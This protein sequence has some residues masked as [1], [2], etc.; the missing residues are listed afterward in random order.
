MSILRLCMVRGNHDL[1]TVKHYTNMLLLLSSC[2]VGSNSLQPR[3]VQ[4]TRLPC[5]S[6]S[7]TVCSNSCPLNW[8]FHPTIS[9][10][11]FPF[12]SYLQSFSYCS[13]GSQGQN[14]EVVYCSL[15]W[16]YWSGLLCPSPGDLLNPGIKPKSL[17]LQAD[18]LLSE[19]PGKPTD[20]GVG[21]LSLLQ[22]LFLTQELNQGLLPCRRI[23]CQLSYQ[24]VPFKH[25]TLLWSEVFWTAKWKCAANTWII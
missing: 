25:K 14:A 3:G 17:A 18:S 20:T 11:V 7:P 19:P 10:S 23:L 13:W 16:E 22:G 2:S 8:W 5:S 4:D 1:S 24:L 15:L 6:P 21:G 12:S 9:S